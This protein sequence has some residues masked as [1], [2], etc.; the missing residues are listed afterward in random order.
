MLGGL[1]RS[2]NSTCGFHV[3]AFGMDGD[4]VGMDRWSFDRLSDKWLAICEEYLRHHGSSFDEPWSGNLSHIRTKLTSV[5]GTAL[6]TFSSH[7]RIAVSV[8]L[9]SGES[10]ISEKS[11]LEMFV[12]SLRESQPVRAAARSQV[13]FQRALDIAER[14]LMITVPWPDELVSDQEHAVIQ[15]LSVHLAAAF[16]RASA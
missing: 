5:A 1:N 15:E 10:P 13:V 2:Q 16:F 14:P 7:G 8:A 9:A 4:L 11:I 6:A 12:K 3:A